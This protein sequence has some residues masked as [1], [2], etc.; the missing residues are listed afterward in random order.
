MVPVP[1][2]FS[3]PPRS[4]AANLAPGGVIIQHY[5]DGQLAYVHAAP[6]VTSA[7]AARCLATDDAAKCNDALA[8][9]KDVQVAVYDGDTGAL[10]FVETRHAAKA[11]QDAAT[12]W[13]SLGEPMCPCGQPL[14]YASQA[15][16]RFVEAMNELH[17]EFIRVTQVLV[18]KTFLVSRH[19]V[20]LHEI[21][22]ETDLAAL[23]FPEV[24]NSESRK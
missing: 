6:G 18:G 7:D 5:H 22:G 11:P 24:S 15:K 16:R 4:I 2:W 20:A 3:G 10:M 21:T 12:G 13:K 17:G 8:S 19:Y 9:G 14:H 23:G 1:S